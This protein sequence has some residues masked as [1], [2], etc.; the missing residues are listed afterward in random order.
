MAESKR[1]L[2]MF[3][4]FFQKLRKRGLLLNWTT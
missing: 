2:M 1:G 3:R 4:P